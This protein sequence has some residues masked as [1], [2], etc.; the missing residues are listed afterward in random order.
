MPLHASAAEPPK[1]AQEKPI[2]RWQTKTNSEILQNLMIAAEQQEKQGLS[3]LER[4]DSKQAGFAGFVPPFG[5]YPG[6]HVRFCD[7]DC[8]KS[9]KPCSHSTAVLHTFVISGVHWNRASWPYRAQ[10]GCTKL[11]VTRRLVLQCV[12]VGTWR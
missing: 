1:V 4:V 7:C 12:L 9:N 8:A 10:I 3:Q 5:A 2:C 11:R 6:P